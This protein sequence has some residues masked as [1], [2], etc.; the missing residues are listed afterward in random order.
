[1]SRPDPH[2]AD[3]LLR[4]APNHTKPSTAFSVAMGDDTDDSG[5]LLGFGGYLSQ[6]QLIAGWVARHP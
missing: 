6:L 5:C 1:M 4:E 3:A 2:E